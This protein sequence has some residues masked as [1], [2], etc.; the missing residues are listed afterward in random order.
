M[1]ELIKKYYEKYN[2]FVLFCGIAYMG[3]ILGFKLKGLRKPVILKGML[4]PLSFTMHYQ[5]LNSL[6]MEGQYDIPE[7]LIIFESKENRANKVMY[8]R[9]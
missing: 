1:D 7:V 3:S 9:L 5:I 4:V 8:N 6:M 2:S